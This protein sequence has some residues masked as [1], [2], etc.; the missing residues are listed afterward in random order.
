MVA[1]AFQ[2]LGRF[3]VTSMST[4]RQGHPNGP[5]ALFCNRCGVPLNT[6]VAPAYPPSPPPPSAV[7]PAPPPQGSPRK[8]AWA[9]YQDRRAARKRREALIALLLFPIALAVVFGWD[10]G[11]DWLIN[12][13]N[14]KTEESPSDATAPRSE[15]PAS[16]TEPTIGRGFGTKDATGDVTLVSCPAV[17]TRSGSSRGTAKFKI[18]NTTGKRSSYSITYVTESP[19]GTIRYESGYVSVQ[20]LEPGQLYETDDSLYR[21]PADAR[22]RLTEVQRT[23]S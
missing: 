21:T 14:D 7:P 13:G 9:D 22:C 19:D 11:T 6:P 2:S 16:S 20:D 3:I 1:H 10:L 17:E 18:V 5:D 12:A 4:C 23:A 15:T 8:S